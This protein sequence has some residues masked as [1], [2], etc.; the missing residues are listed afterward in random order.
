MKQFK[1]LFLMSLACLFTFQNVQAQ[2]QAIAGKEQVKV[3]EISIIRAKLM[4]RND[5]ALMVDVREK[6]EIAA[7]AYDVENIV[8]IPLSEFSD[9]MSEIPKDK[10]LI[11]VC[12]SGGRSRLA[13]GT[14]LQNGYTTVVNMAG[15]MRA[16]QAKDLGVI[17]NEKGSSKKA[18]CSDPNSKNCKPDGTCKKGSKDGKKCC[19]SK[20]KKCS[21]KS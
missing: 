14:L 5:D 2:E 20:G 9:R 13:A 11:M 12:Q 19:A 15:G 7:V 6:N 17:T 4:E 1:F 18:C 21:K 10:Q 8:H 3:E 16:W